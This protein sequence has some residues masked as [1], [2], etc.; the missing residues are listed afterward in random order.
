[1][2]KDN[3]ILKD[4]EEFHH[5]LNVGAFTSGMINTILYSSDSELQEY[6]EVFKKLIFKNCPINGISIGIPKGYTFKEAANDLVKIIYQKLNESSDS[7]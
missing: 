6:R 1:M 3:N 7:N 5:I 2:L 4:S